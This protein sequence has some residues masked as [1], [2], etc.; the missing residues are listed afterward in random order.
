MKRYSVSFAESAAEDLAASFEWGVETWGKERA[1]QWYLETRNSIRD[2]LT[3]F[4]LSHAVAP[5]NAEYDVEVR[6][7]LI[8]RY[9]ILY[10]VTDDMV[11][12]L[13]ILGPYTK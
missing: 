3:S 11:T 6:Q 12:V 4:P 10:N 7:M 13:H 5:D 8:G 1:R 2:M 9:R